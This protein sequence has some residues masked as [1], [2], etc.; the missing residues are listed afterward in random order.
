MGI[1][2]EKLLPGKLDSKFLAELIKQYTHQ[3]GKGIHVGAGIGQDAAVIDIGDHY[4]IAKTDP[5]TFTTQHLGY[6]AVHV[7][8]NDIACMGGEPKYFLATL[9]LPEKTATKNMAK[10]IFKDIYHTCD[11][12]NISYIGGHTEI[13]LGVK[14]P[15]LVGQ[16]LGLAQ[17]E[18]LINKNE[19]KEGDRLIV[20]GQIPL[21]AT[22]I[23]ARDK[24]KELEGYF[25][26]E[27]VK[28]C[29]NF[30]FRPGISVLPAARLC[31]KHARIHA[32]HD[33]TEGGIGTAIHEMMSETGWG[34]TVNADEIPQLPEGKLLCDH[35]QLD[36]LGC[37]SSGSLLALVPASDVQSLLH[38]L[39]VRGMIANK[40]GKVTKKGDPLVLVRDGK[41]SLMPEFPQDELIKIFD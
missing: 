23:I 39:K 15:I 11:K 3:Q 28:R 12:E 9:L 37:I 26:S 40:A 20:I 29:Q 30:L 14:N 31:R 1:K 17:K 4:L 34:L 13:T 27:F 41:S 5:I 38:H 25:S 22:S 6:Y 7:N 19:I 32:F 24:E 2:F 16:M 21:E 10:E 8:S 36:P 33:A 35:Y 18:H